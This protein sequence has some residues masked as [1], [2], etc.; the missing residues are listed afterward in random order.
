MI[1]D[2]SK[3]DLTFV[4]RNSTRYGYGRKRGRIIQEYCKYLFSHTLKT[5]ILP[6]VPRAERNWPRKKLNSVQKEV[7][8]WRPRSASKLMRKALAKFFS[9]KI[10]HCTTF[11]CH[12]KYLYSC[13]NH[14]LQWFKLICK[15]SATKITMN[16]FAMSSKCLLPSH[17]RSSMKSRLLG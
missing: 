8:R 14:S 6:T 1:R 10:H 17:S 2:H 13:L 9:C 5:A 7:F 15:T 4:G 3:T 16:Q 12:D 11:S